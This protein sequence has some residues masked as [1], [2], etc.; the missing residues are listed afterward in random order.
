MLDGD[1]ECFDLHYSNTKDIN[2]VHKAQDNSH[3]KI[4]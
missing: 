1:C 3:I 2:F 4:P